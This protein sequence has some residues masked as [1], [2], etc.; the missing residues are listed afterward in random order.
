MNKP[1]WA[2]LS[3]DALIEQLARMRYARGKISADIAAINQ[4]LQERGIPWKDT[5]RS[6]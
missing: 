5:Q 6:R 2:T 1:G 3:T 4:V